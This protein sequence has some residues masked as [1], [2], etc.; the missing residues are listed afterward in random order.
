[1]LVTDGPMM[2]PELTMFYVT[3]VGSLTRSAGQHGQVDY[4]RVNGVGQM[5]V[6]NETDHR[7]QCA[8]T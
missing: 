8:R 6:E 2:M 3:D 5:G 7:V 4:H 1:M